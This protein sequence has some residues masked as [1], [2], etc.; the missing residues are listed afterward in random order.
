M[1]HLFYKLVITS[2]ILKLFGKVPLCTCLLKSSTIIVAKISE[3]SLMSFAGIS[4]D[5]EVFLGLRFLISLTTKGFVISLKLRLGFSILSICL[6]LSMIDVK[7]FL[8]DLVTSLTLCA[9]IPRFGMMPTKD[10]LMVLASAFSDVITAD[11]LIREIV[12]HVT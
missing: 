8:S 9:S 1:A 10:S 7:E 6:Y 4:L 3:N 12:L 11:F 2:D 5:C